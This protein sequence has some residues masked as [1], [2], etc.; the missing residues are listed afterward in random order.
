MDRKNRSEKT[1]PEHVEKKF[2]YISDGWTTDGERCDALVLKAIGSGRYEIAGE[3]DC[4]YFYRVHGRRL[5]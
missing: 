5:E 4:A 2:L 1:E 3:E